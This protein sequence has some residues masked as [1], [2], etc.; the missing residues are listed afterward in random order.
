VIIAVLLLLKV[1]DIE[2][3]AERLDGVCN[4]RL[5]ADR[6]GL[7]ADEKSGIE[8]GVGTVLDC[9]PTVDVLKLWITK[10]RSTVRILR[11]LL[12]DKASDELVQKLDHLRMSAS[13]LVHHQYS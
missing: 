3:L 8:A 13:Y 5:T 4:W 7:S 2:D 9:V 6:L 12:V 1:Y 11:Q 10:D